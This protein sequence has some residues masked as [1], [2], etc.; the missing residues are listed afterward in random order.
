MD[1]L[2]LIGLEGIV[3]VLSA[4]TKQQAIRELAHRAAAMT[5]A[6]EAEIVAVLTERERAGSTGVGGGVAIPHGTMKSLDRIY[7]VFARLPRPIDYDAIDEQ[8]VDLLFLLL[9]PENAG[10]E[11]L[12]ALARIARLFRAPDVATKLRAAA[13]TAALY[14][15]LAAEARPDAA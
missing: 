14:A 2:D 11:H 9:A 6:G 1:L 3:P 13:D 12:K 8:P 15:V 4:K 7:G 10:A 5:G